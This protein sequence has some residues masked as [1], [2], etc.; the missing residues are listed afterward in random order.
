MTDF[1]LYLET[2][3]LIYALEGDNDE[4]RSYFRLLFRKLNSYEV[5][6]SELSLAEML[7]KPYATDNQDLIERYKGLF[8]LDG[9]GFITVVPV[10]TDV[11]SHAAGF[12]GRQMRFLKRN[13]KLPDCIHAATAYLSGSTHFMT[14]DDGMKLWD[15][16]QM[17]EP[18]SAGI[19]NRLH[20]LP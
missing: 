16:I 11:L 13:P 3:P 18:S 15:Q 4:L 6:T 12:R 19:E 17:V 1:R 2:N 7:V 10:S 14:K 5:F 9:N 20:T 8:R